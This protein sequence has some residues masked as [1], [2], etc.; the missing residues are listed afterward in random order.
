MAESRDNRLIGWWQTSGG[1]ADPSSPDRIH[2]E[3]NGLYFVENDVP[4]RFTWWDGGTWQ[5]PSPAQLSLSVANDAVETYRFSIDDARLS[6][7]DAGGR[8]HTY[9]RVSA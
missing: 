1:G 5:T 6:I 2:F 3:A 8:T 4:D 9:T 7:T